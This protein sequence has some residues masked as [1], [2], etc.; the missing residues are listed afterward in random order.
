MKRIFV[1]FCALVLFGCTADDE[2]S[3]KIEIEVDG[4]SAII[5]K[6]SS[7]N[8]GI[9][10]FDFYNNFGIT[11]GGLWSGHSIY[12][13]H[14]PGSAQLQSLEYYPINTAYDSHQDVYRPLDAYQSDVELETD[15]FIKGTFSGEFVNQQ[16][17]S[18]QIS[19]QFKIYK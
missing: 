17:D 10:G 15:D 6:A 4:V 8:S 9:A 14:S 18:K 12:F 19:G 3:G 11:Y 13:T 2:R 16:G 1:V 7:V 5:K